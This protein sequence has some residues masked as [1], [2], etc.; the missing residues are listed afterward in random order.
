M[1]NPRLLDSRLRN[2]QYHTGF[3]LSN[4]KQAA[5]PGP[6]ITTTH[7]INWC[8]ETAEHI[9]IILLRFL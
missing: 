6:I 2:L 7:Y 5:D 4:A 9:I 1:N 8:Q 3:L